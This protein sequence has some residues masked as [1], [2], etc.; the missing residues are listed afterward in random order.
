MRMDMS[1]KAPRSNVEM[2]IC[3][4]LAGIFIYSM[5]IGI[6]LLHV[7]FVHE[8]LCNISIPSTTFNLLVYSESY[9]CM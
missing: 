7:K 6:D 8:I 3:A 1:G 4:V 2:F 5:F 9:F